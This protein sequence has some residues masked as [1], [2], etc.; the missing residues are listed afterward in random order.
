MTGSA[1]FEELV[2]TFVGLPGVE[3]PAATGRGFGAQAL[4]A[5][6]RIFAMCPRESLVLKLPAER[7]TQLIAED[8]AGPFDAGKGRPMREWLT[9]AGDD[10]ATWLSLAH[11]AYA[12]ARRGSAS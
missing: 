11:E 6:G 12:Y 5:E 4:K 9:V 8:V 2:D 3:P 7:V 1:T 10:P